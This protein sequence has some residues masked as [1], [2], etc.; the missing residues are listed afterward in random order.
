MP[1]SWPGL[2]DCFPAKRRQPPDSN[3]MTSLSAQ[4]VHVVLLMLIAAW[5]SA[6]EFHYLK[7]GKIVRIDSYRFTVSMFAENAAV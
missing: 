7:Q 3:G 5:F 6:L 1:L 2:N 4:Y